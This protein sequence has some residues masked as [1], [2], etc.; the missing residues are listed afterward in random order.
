MVYMPGIAP[1]QQIPVLNVIDWGTCYQVL[2]PVDGMSAKKIW[3]AFTRSWVRMFGMPE[4]VI[5]DQGREFMG[6]FAQNAGEAGAIVRMIGARAP[7]Q[8]GRT[9]RHG[10]IA[11]GVLGK[12]KDQMNPGDYDEWVQCLNA[13]EAAK[14]RLFNRSGFSPAQR[15]LGQNLRLPGSLMS[16]DKLEA[17]L[18]CG[19]A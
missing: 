14:N 2:E 5:A 7:W 1:D 10:G 11:K 8:N 6:D 16:D 13:V 4:V 19:G 12:V 18:V 3:S 17:S 15:Q 9:E